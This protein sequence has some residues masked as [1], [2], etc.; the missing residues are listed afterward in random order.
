MKKNKYI[1]TLLIVTI[2]TLSISCG[3]SFL[4]ETPTQYVSVEDVAK[5]GSIYSEIL[6]GTLSGSYNLMY[7][8]ES[9]GTTDHTDF[10]QKSY[11]IYYDFLSGDMALTQNSYNW[12]NNFCQLL[13]TIDYTQTQANYSAWRYYYRIIGAANKIIEAV[14]GNDGIITD[15][16][17]STM[18]QAK[19]L[20]AYAYFHLTQLY[21][22]E[23]SP[24]SKV[25]P[26]YIETGSE[27][28]EQSETKV[29]YDQ[30]I[31]DLTQGYT[32]LAGEKRS[33]LF[34]VNEDVAKTLL[35]YVYASMGTSEANMKAKNLAEEVIAHANLPVTS[36]QDV[37]GGFNSVNSPSW[38]WG[39]NI[40]T[41]A[42][43]D[44]VSW[45]GQIDVFTYSYQWAGDKKAIDEGL[46]NQIKDSDIRK[47][48][49]ATQADI[50]A[51]EGELEDS[52]LLAPINK[53]YNSGRISGGQRVVEDDYIYMRIDELYLLSAE[54]SAKE[55]IVI[56]ARNRLKDILENRFDNPADY[57]YV[58]TLTGQD[59]V[60]EI[61]LQT[62]IEFY[63]E[64]K[65][66]AALKRNKGT[67]NRGPNHLYLV[68]EP[69]L[70]N[71][72][73]LTLEIPQSEIQ[74]N[75]FINK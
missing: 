50:D 18:G 31:D 36:K 14:G 56:D 66:Y 13:I 53:F 9:G 57:A 39:S 7:V 55:G 3:D 34:E 11:D 1:K 27:S 58:D 41:D 33:Q 59:L 49:F 20:R 60:D 46:Y 70:Y 28:H 47:T 68:G 37:V 45:W 12:Y 43:L 40:T 19:T 73:R 54:M 63:G 32:L 52:D 38:L 16:N 75:P 6:K 23:Y 64:G 51:S 44:L 71:D 21:I 8:T 29:I 26:L 48:Q 15:S 4:E 65:S 61:Y 35:A 69:I 42:G 22:T 10:G 24:T 74:N 62:R 17:K 72:D 67:V 2:A 25:L 5:T 30:M